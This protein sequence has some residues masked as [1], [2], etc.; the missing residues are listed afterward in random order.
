[1]YKNKN[2]VLRGGNNGVIKNTIALTLINYLLCY[3]LSS[4]EV[5]VDLKNFFIIFLLSTVICWCSK[6]YQSKRIVFV[7]LLLFAIFGYSIPLIGYYTEP[8]FL[9]RLMK[10]FL[11]FYSLAAFVVLLPLIVEKNIFIF[12]FILSLILFL[13]SLPTL[14]VCGYYLTM[15]TKLS[16]DTLMALFQTNIQEAKEFLDTYFNAVDILS[17]IFLIVFFLAVINFL[18]KK[19]FVSVKQKYN[20]KL[21]VVL[22]SLTMFSTYMF[23]AKTYIARTFNNTNYL[24]KNMQKFEQYKNERINLLQAENEVKSLSEDSFALIIGETHTRS[25]LSVSGYHRETTPWLRESIEKGKVVFLK[26]AFSCAA[27]T[28]P[29]LEYALTQKN[30]YNN[31]PMQ[32]AMTIVELAREAG[33]NVVWVTN[34]QNDTIAG[35]IAGEANNT[36]WANKSNNDTYL[37]QK[38]GI[39]DRLILYELD[40]LQQNSQKTLYVI[41]LLGS[42]ADYSCRYPNEFNKWNESNILNAYDN[43]ILYNDYIME[44][45]ANKLFTKLDVKA[46]MYFADHGEELNKFYCHGTDFFLTNYKKYESVKN[47]VKIPAYFIFSEKYKQ[48]YP[49]QYNIIKNNADK[50]FTNDL[51]FES[52]LGL[53]QVESKYINKKFAITSSQYDMNLDD[54]YTIHGKISLKEVL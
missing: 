18:I 19:L 27:Q 43:S 34:Q 22:L 24:L 26:N 31:T 5:L 53:M 44:H 21:V 49:A 35:L 10:D 4:R 37:R 48:K 12:K 42:H 20:S 14:L 15:K 17:I 13:V 51:V 28:Q 39:D 46:I 45:M 9:Q 1:M 30:Q 11:F 50:Y 54:L 36:I 7:T 6:F 38:N 16:S 40:K 2:I 33:F 23:F 41:H 29:A 25:N 47:I 3:F 52:M 8:F 32:K